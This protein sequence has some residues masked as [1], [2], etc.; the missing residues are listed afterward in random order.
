[1]AAVTDYYLVTHHFITL[2]FTANVVLILVNLY[3]VEGIENDASARP[4]NV[5]SASCDLNR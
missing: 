5:T 3:S 4:P 1:M 2:I